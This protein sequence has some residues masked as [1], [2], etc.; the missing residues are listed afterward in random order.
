MIKRQLPL[1]IA[2]AMGVIFIIQFFIPHQISQDLLTWVNKWLMII[3]GISLLL[4]IYSLLN[5]HYLQIFRNKPGW[6][7]SLI[8]FFSFLISVVVGFT[9]SLINVILPLPE[10]SVQSAEQVKEWYRITGLKD[11]SSLDWIFRHGI[12]PLSAT[13]FSIIGFFIA[14]AAFRAFRAR[15][16]EATLLLLAAVFI[17]LGQTP[18]GGMLWSGIPDIMTWI[19]ST[20]NTAA[21]RAILFG[22]AMGSISF[23]LKIIFGIERAYLGGKN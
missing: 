15:S 3:G 21:K 19:L 2:F 5:F 22:I 18:L 16:L 23:S 13:M 10:S 6:G 12:T 11:G 1:L 7:F 14:S 4:G 17:M 9:P 8:M 20:P